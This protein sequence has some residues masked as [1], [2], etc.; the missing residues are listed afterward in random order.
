YSRGMAWYKTA[1]IDST[2]PVAYRH[3]AGR[4][5][6]HAQ[7][8]DARLGYARDNWSISTFA[9]YHRSD[10]SFDNLGGGD[11]QLDHQLTTGIA[12]HLDV[13]PD[14]QFDQSFGYS[15]DRGF[16][17]ANDPTI[18]TDQINSQR[19]STST[20]LTHQE[21]GFHLFGL[22]LSGETKLAYD[23]TREQAF[24]PID[25]PNG[26]PTRNDSAFSLH[27]SATLGSVT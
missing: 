3:E 10:L 25:I 15:N 26:V 19:I 17:Y 12:F 6:Y 21:R 11:R 5:P 24:L 27:Q 4:N 22:P 9:L 20:S 23:F 13:T 18:P 1:G 7:G 14:T 16:I 8:L 2:R